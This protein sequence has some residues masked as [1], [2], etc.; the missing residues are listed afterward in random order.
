MGQETSRPALY[1]PISK[2]LP[3]Y[4]AYGHDERRE[5]AEKGVKPFDSEGDRE[6][7]IYDKGAIRVKIEP[8]KDGKDVPEAFRAFKKDVELRLER[9][10][11]D[12]PD[13]GGE[14]SSNQAAGN[15]RAKVQGERGR[16]M[17]QPTVRKEFV[18][19]PPAYGDVKKG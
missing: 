6:Q 13:G 10:L 14:G 16:E 8:K 2:A 3:H 12:V 15:G 18:D 4:S 1:H 7:F 5:W 9:L 17:V 11:R 19:A